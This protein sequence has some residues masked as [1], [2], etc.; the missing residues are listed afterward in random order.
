[1]CGH[2]VEYLLI[3]LESGEHWGPYLTIS[4]ARSQSERL[5]LGKWEVVALDGDGLVTP[6]FP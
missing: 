4:E 2:D 3:D 6:V 5:D 1:M